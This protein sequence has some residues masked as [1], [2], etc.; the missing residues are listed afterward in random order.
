MA[1]A[2]QVEGIGTVTPWPSSCT[3]GNKATPQDEPEGRWSGEALIYAMD[4]PYLGHS[5]IILSTADTRFAGMETMMWFLDDGVGNAMCGDRI[6]CD[7]HA[8][9]LLSIGYKVAK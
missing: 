1:L 5:E 4:P 3:C 9:F 6:Q 2:A 8:E 7:T